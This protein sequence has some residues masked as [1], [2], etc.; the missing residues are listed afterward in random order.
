MEK[1]RGID[2]ASGKAVYDK[3][4]R[5]WVAYLN[6]LHK[7]RNTGVGWKWFIDVFAA[8][9]L[10]FTL[11]GLGLLYMYADGRKITWPL[12]GAGLVIPLILALIFI[13]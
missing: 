13:H 3:T 9:C 6:D 8:G 2:K 4:T 10:I 5:G 12:V 7:G 1:D 11:S